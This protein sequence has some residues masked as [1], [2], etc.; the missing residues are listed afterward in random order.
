MALERTDGPTALVLS[1]QSLP[2]LDTGALDDGADVALEI[3]ATGS[4][5]SLALGVAEVLRSEGYGVRVVSA[6]DRSRYTPDRSVTRV[7]IEAGSTPAWSG[8]VDL[9]IGIDDFGASGPGEDVLAFHGFTVADVL[10]RIRPLLG[11][12]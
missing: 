11:P 3:V 10:E 9:A 6:L 7:S 4:E 1:R 8:V 5:V 2:Q 12:A